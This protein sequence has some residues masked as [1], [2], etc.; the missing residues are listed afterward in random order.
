MTSKPE[1]IGLGLAVSQQIVQSHGGS[2]FFSRQNGE[3]NVEVHLPLTG[4]VPGCLSA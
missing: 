4:L 1:G 3:T 2:I